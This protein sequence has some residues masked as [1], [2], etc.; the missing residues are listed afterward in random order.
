MW[1]FHGAQ[2]SVVPAEESRKIHKAFHQAGFRI[3]T[4]NIQIWDTSPGTLHFSDALLWD[5]LFQQRKSEKD[6]GRNDER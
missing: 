1:L 5:W 4:R 2:D 6:G 3:K